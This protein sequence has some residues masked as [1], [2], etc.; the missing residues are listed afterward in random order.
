MSQVMRCKFRL[1]TVKATEMMTANGSE[2]GVYVQFGAVY[3]QDEKK[4]NDPANENSIFGKYTPHGS[5]EATI[6]NPHL[7]EA[8]PRLLGREFYIDFSVAS[9]AGA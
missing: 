2:K 5:Y 3:E 4:R 1:N 9:E 7:V 8:L 6:Y